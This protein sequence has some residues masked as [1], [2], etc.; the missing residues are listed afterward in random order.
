MFILCFSRYSSGVNFGLETGSGST[1]VSLGDPFASLEF[2][3][4]PS[5]LTSVLI[6]SIFEAG[7]S[8]SNSPFVPETIIFVGDSSAIITN[9]FETQ[10]H[11]H[12]YILQI[13]AYWA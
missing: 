6:F 12:K 10:Y 4:E 7:S 5:V 13:C 1:G 2:T 11:S 8:C 3:S 9:Y